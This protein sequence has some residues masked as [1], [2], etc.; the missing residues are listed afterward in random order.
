M[1]AKNTDPNA[2]NDREK[3]PK[4]IDHGIFKIEDPELPMGKKDIKPSEQAVTVPR[5]PITL[6][7]LDDR[8][9][10]AAN[11]PLITNIPKK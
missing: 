7:A 2:S 10:H 1:G 5:A 11:K 6:A 3:E 9:K 8:P 4:G